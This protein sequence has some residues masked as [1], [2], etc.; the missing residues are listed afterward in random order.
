LENIVGGQI[1]K[2]GEFPYM[3]LLGY[4]ITGKIYYL[5][6]GSAINAKYIL[7]AAHCHSNGR[8]IR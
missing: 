5:C 4:N 2:L 7:T 8:P 6:G 1:A 3:A